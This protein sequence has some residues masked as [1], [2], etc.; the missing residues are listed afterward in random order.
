[1]RSSEEELLEAARRGDERAYDRLVSPHRNALH[2]HCYRMLASLH[3]AED[4]VQET[5]LGAWQGLSRFEG[6]SAF[7]TWLFTIATHACLRIVARRRSRVLTLDDTPAAD[8]HAELGDP[9]E[10]GVWLEPYPDERMGIGDELASP[11]AR[12]EQRES[13]EL[14]F[15]AALQ[16]LPATQRAVLI[17][18]DVLGFSAEETGASL[19]TSVASVNSALQRARAALGERLPEPSQRATRSTLGDAQLARLVER[20]VDAWRT[21]DVDAIVAMLADDA[22][23]TMPP[24]PSWFRGREDIRTFLARKVLTLRWRFLATQASG[25]PAMAAYRF[26]PESD[27]YRLEVINVLSFRGEQVV[28]IHAFQTASVCARFGLPEALPA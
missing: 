28:G 2:A 14:A 15:V 5:L 26:R 17:L 4:A 1:M 8:P 12:Y 24:L 20:F 3:D 10:E 9:V 19:D 27:T 18:R 6:R 23:F 22:T 7:R 21:A 11:E 13:I 25:Q 16:H